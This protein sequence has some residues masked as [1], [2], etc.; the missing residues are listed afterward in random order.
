[1]YKISLVIYYE[2]NVENRSTVVKV[3]IKNHVFC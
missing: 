2:E 3:M 1:M